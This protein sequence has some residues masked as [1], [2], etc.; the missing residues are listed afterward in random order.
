MIYYFG[1]FKNISLLKSNL[2]TKEKEKEIKAKKQKEKE[3]IDIIKSKYLPDSKPIYIT[4]KDH[5]IEQFIYDLEK[6]VFC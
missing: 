3:N 1:K 4:V 6:A 2:S 5:N